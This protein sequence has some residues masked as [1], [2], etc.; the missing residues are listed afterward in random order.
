MVLDEMRKCHHVL[1]M[2][3]IAFVAIVSFCTSKSQISKYFQEKQL[4]SKISIG[5]PIGRDA[6]T[7]PQVDKYFSRG[8]IQPIINGSAT[9]AHRDNATNYSIH[10][11]PRDAKLTLK[12]PY[13]IVQIG[14]PR[15]ASTFQFELLHVIVG[16]RGHQSSSRLI[17]SG[18]T[19]SVIDE[20]TGK[21]LK[22]IRK[23]LYVSEINNSSFVARSHAIPNFT[24]D[25][26]DSNGIVLFESVPQLSKKRV[27]N[28]LYTQDLSSMYNCSLCEV[29]KYQQLFNLT[30]AEVEDVKEYMHYFE[31]LRQCCGLQMSKFNRLRL[32]GCNV[33][34]YHSL[35]SY[36]NCEAENL[37]LVE[38]S[39][40]AHLLRNYSRTNGYQFN[41][42][43]PGD[44]ARFDAVIISGKDF[45]GMPFEGCEKGMERIKQ[46]LK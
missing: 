19:A 30:S 15:S 5:S 29:E 44:C 43:N 18:I 33:S 6:S 3:M 14:L 24:A 9:V 34:Q 32:H 27:R 11:S 22:G 42:A 36:P 17:D 1:L 13:R 38:H 37:T 31:R 39:F 40:N 16:M 8:K 45:N 2:V 21:E 23:H 20:K 12:A 26:Y 10:V 28:A 35:P 46:K 4:T 25:F 7:P 41:W